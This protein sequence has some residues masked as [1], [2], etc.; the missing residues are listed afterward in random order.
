MTAPAIRKP[1]RIRSGDVV[2]VVAPSGAVNADRLALGVRVLERWGLEVR[3]GAGV[4]ERRAYLAG[5]DDERRSDLERM[6]GDPAVRAVF[7]A[8]GGY[9]SQRLVPSLDLGP[10]ARAPKPIVGYSDVTALLAAVVS[11][12]VVGFHGPMVADDLARGLSLRAETHLRALLTDPAYRW[13]AEVPVTVRPGR[14]TGRLLGGCLSVLVTTLGTPYAPDTDGAILFLEDV[15]EGPYRLDRLLTQMAQAGKLTR[16][17]GLVFGTMASCPTV[18]GYGPL[19]VV[20]ACCA[21][22]AC[23]VGFGL[24]AGHDVGGPGVLNLALP[25]G[26]EVEL[27]TSRGRLAALDSAVV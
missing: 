18:D 7:C 22:L 26:V 8:R 5:H 2:A 16:L 3:L 12:G 10:L 20:R 15:R 27:D 25:L 21:E 23:P 19:D 11:A 17:A 13:E 6:I 4:L 1:P 9:G 14:A 24:P